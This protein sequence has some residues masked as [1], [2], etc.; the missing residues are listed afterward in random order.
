[1]N[2]VMSDGW[3]LLFLAL[4]GAVNLAAS[5]LMLSHYEDIFGKG[6]SDSTMYQWLP[7]VVIAWILASTAGLFIMFGDQIFAS[8]LFI[9]S[10]IVFDLILL[11]NVVT[12][13]QQLNF[14]RK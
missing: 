3:I 8:W 14:W 1:M 6:S 11:M 4:H 5:L 10:I 13:P 12:L 7:L 2:H 9:K